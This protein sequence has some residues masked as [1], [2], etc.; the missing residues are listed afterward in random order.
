ML[1]VKSVRAFG[2]SFG[3]KLRSNNFPKLHPMEDMDLTAVPLQG[4]NA[5]RSAYATMHAKVR[6]RLLEAEGELLKSQVHLLEEQQAERLA[7]EREEALFMKTMREVQQTGGQ[8]ALYPIG[9]DA[10]RIMDFIRGGYFDRSSRSEKYRVRATGV[11]LRIP[12]TYHPLARYQSTAAFASH[13]VEEH[14]LQG[15]SFDG[16]A[17]AIV[18]AGQDPFPEAMLRGLFS[19]S[20]LLLSIPGA[21]IHAEAYA[22]GYL[23]AADGTIPVFDN[24]KG[25]G[26]PIGH[27]RVFAQPASVAILFTF[28][29]GWKVLPADWM[30][31]GFRGILSAADWDDM[32]DALRDSGVIRA[33]PLSDLS[34]AFRRIG[35]G[36]PDGYMEV[37]GA[38]ERL[39]AVERD[40]VASGLTGQALL[41]A[42][43]RATAPALAA[44]RETLEALMQRDGAP[45]KAR[46]AA[47]A[48]LAHW[49]RYA[50]LLTHA[51]LEAEPARPEHGIPLLSQGGRTFLYAPSVSAAM[52]YSRVYSLIATCHARHQDP[53]TVMQQYLD[54]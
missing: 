52:T 2:I 1:R 35:E 29:W 28:T 54:A 8:D 53:R 10:Y 24:Q 13:L 5:E 30:I 39:M 44:V 23:V 41:E 38:L 49:P 12:R 26:K 20:V 27:Y 17:R 51:E 33:C 50:A 22:R 14:L 46:R 31:E 45:S 42:R 48:A 7:S 34:D 16:V 9:E 25:V 4:W 15:R 6:I 37:V 19:T 21:G 43:A 40:H 36:V 47:R 18:K 11:V 32:D 3:Q